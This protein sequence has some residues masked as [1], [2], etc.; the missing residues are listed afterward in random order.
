MLPKA[1]TRSS[2]KSRWVPAV[3]WLWVAG[4]LS[5]ILWEIT[6]SVQP[7]YVHEEASDYGL[8]LVSTTTTTTTPPPPPRNRIDPVGRHSN[9]LLQGQF[10][11]D[12]SPQTIQWWV[13]TWSAFFEKILVVGPFSK[14]TQRELTQMGIQHRYGVPGGRDPSSP[15]CYANLMQ[16]LL[17]IQ[18]DP[19]LDG[20]LYIH[21]DLLV[22]L[23]NYTIHGRFPKDTIIMNSVVYS[24]KEGSLQHQKSEHWIDIERGPSS[25]TNSSLPR[26]ISFRGYDNTT[27]QGWKALYKNIHP[28]WHFYE[29]CLP[30]EAKIAAYD[31]RIDEYLHHGRSWRLPGHRLVDNLWLPKVYASDFVKAAQIHA[32]HE[33]YLECAFPSIL[34]MISQKDYNYNDYNSAT[35]RGR[36]P[37]SLQSSKP[38]HQ[39]QIKEVPLCTTA[40]YYAKARGRPKMIYNCLKDGVVGNHEFGVY[41]PIKIN[42]DPQAF[43]N[44]VHL[45][46]GSSWRAFNWTPYWKI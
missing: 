13:E 42:Y 29:W 6:S 38:T 34:E 33:N 40:K 46:Q 31:P 36:T 16:S 17:E 26:K 37:P 14:E 45:V 22:N 28:H 11:R 10:N 21:D 5:V 23:T 8:F 39:L 2:T 3:R 43:R 32:D 19:H 25:S 18:T 12:A 41:H 9:A 1:P 24:Q 27:Y 20:V 15:S 30:T 44:M 4:I 35:T 7:V